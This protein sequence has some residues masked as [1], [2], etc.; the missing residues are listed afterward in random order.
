MSKVV[1]EEFVSVKS[2]MKTIKSINKSIKNLRKIMDD[3]PYVPKTL[4]M[5]TPE[6]IYFERPDCKGC[7][8]SCSNCKVVW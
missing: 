2:L 5:I 7:T 1:S 4:E 3:M 8:D 6:V